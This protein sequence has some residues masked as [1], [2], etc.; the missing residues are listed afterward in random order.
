MGFV[1]E[2]PEAD[3]SGSLYDTSQPGNGNGGHL[4]GLDFAPEKKK[5]LLEYLK[6]L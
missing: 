2:G 3:K 1:S 4:Y 5:A 6:T